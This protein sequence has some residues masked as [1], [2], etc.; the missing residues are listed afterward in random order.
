MLKNF[1]VSN[2]AGRVLGIFR[3][4]D[5]AEA[6]GELGA[7]KGWKHMY[8]ATAREVTPIAHIG[9]PI[10]PELDVEKWREFVAERLAARVGFAVTVEKPVSYFSISSKF[11]TPQQ[12]ADIELALEDLLDEFC[13]AKERTS[14]P[15][16]P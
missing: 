8:Q 2:A 15:A 11:A 3:G 16:P 6:L 1:E 12:A 14:R 9:S 10:L 4:E 5:E 7:T 13:A